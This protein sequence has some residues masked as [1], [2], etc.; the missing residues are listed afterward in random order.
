[1]EKQRKGEVIV[2]KGS[3]LWLGIAVLLFIPA[4]ALFSGCGSSSSDGGG[5]TGTVSLGLTDATIDEVKAIY[6]TIKEVSVHKEGGSGWDV[7]AEPNQT[8]NLLELVNGVRETLGIAELEA[9]HYTQLRMKVGEEPDD[10]I[11]FLGIRHSSYGDEYGNYVIDNSDVCH[12]LKMPSGYQSGVKVVCGFDINANQTTELVLDFDASRSI[13]EAGSSDNLLL[14]PTIKV[15]RTEE[16]AIIDGTVTDGAYGLPGVL[17]SV[18]SFDP[19]PASGDDKDRVLV[20]AS[21][22][23]DENGSYVIFIAP[24]TYS[25]VAYKDGCSQDCAAIVAVTNGSHTQD[26]EIVELD[27]SSIGTISGD[28]SIANGSDQ[29]HVTISFRQ[30]TQCNGQYKDI[31]LKSINVAVNGD[32][33]GTYGET[34]PA[35]TYTAVASTYDRITQSEAAEIEAGENTVLGFQLPE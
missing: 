17:V 5:G 2:M 3:R 9:G 13:V 22:I 1:M 20:Q 33:I 32:G 8:Y 23:T 26:L 6:V 24:G 11:N 31:E 25:L 10:G 21:T 19:E 16:C 12:E 35:G 15:L 18:Q 4:L 14:K 27:P 7:I 34:L 30:S 28:I 29:Q